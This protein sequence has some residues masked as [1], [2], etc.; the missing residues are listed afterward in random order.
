MGWWVGGA[1][2][3]MAL[4]VRLW[5][6][7]GPWLLP[8]IPCSQAHFEA[9]PGTFASPAPDPNQAETC[10]GMGEEETR[11]YVAALVAEQ[12]GVPGFELQ[13]EQVGR[14]ACRQERME[15]GGRRC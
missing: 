8:G 5:M 9:A 1:W 7:R 11:E 15:G 2:E 3:E 13:P 14:E 4:V 12:L 10:E 6:G